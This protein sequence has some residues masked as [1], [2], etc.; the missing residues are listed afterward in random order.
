MARKKNQSLEQDLKTIEEITEKLENGSIELE[1]AIKLYKTGMDLS[2]Q[3]M[4][5][6]ADIEK[7]VMVLYKNDDG[8]IEETIFDV[9]RIEEI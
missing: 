9:K 7:E 8:E 2:K 1:E 5:R 3:C 6:L 4:D